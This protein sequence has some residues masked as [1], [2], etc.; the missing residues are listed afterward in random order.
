[1]SQPGPLSIG[2]ITDL[3]RILQEHPEWREQLRTLLLS[4]ELLQHPRRFEEFVQQEHLPLQQAVQT[5]TEQMTQL[6]RQVSLLAHHLEQ[7]TQRMERVE[8]Q[9]EALT[10]RVNDLTQRMERVEAQIEALTQRVNDLT[11][12]MERVEAQ[13]EALTQRVND[14]TQRMERVE[15]QIEA[16]TQRVND[17]TQ[18]MDELTQ[19]VNDLTQRMIDLTE[20]M[21]R[22]ERDLGELKGAMQELRAAQKAP[23]YFANLGFYRIK[24]FE[25]V[26]LGERLEKALEEN[27]LTPEE[28][29]DLMQLDLIVVARRVHEP[30]L[31]LFAVEVSWTVDSYDVERAARRAQLLHKL[32]AD[33][34]PT[35]QPVAW[36][37]RFTA[38]AQDQ[39]HA[40]GVK[41]LLFERP[42]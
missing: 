26:E 29:Q 7:L 18:R 15:A 39:A 32:Y 14:L 23:A 21:E 40:L 36:G 11:Q 19:R 4:D 3:V 20:R 9:I 1:M 2:S 34:K 41:L 30:H 28:Y 5:L 17:L 27:Q 38:Q 31:Y 37:T 8:A 25:P 12:R 13:I 24:A 22:A 6:T 42:R 16:L 10:Q 33:E 35:I